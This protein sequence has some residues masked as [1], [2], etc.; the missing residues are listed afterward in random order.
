MSEKFE[1]LIRDLKTSAKNVTSAYEWGSNV[2]GAER[3]LN[4][5]RDKLLGEITKLETELAEMKDRIAWKGTD[6]LPNIAGGYQ[7]VV[8]GM[9]RFPCNFL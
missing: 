2:I 3:E 1:E 9:D 5:E 7:V 4:E 6:R 8:C